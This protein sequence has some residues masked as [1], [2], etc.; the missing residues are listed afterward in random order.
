MPYGWG[1]MDAL[2]IWQAEAFATVIRGP[3][4]SLIL[5]RPAGA[6]KDG[7]GHPPPRYLCYPICLR[8]RAKRCQLAT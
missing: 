5:R 7:A 3:L 6:S 8:S 2:C 1:L 4:S